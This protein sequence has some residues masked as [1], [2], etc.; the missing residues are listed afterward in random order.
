MP[1]GGLRAAAR[2]WSICVVSRA[3]L[4]LIIEDDP[5]S[6]GALSLILSDWGADVIAGAS[7]AELMPKLESRRAAA[8]II[9]DFCLGEGPNGVLAAQSLL[10]LLPS[11]PVLVLTSAF[12]NRAASDASDAGFDFMAKPARAEA[13]VA[14]LEQH[15]G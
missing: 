8:A 11:A 9:A 12:G 4:I 13:I 2:L 7:L 6:A 1:S 5:A 14:W 10:Q 3:P 15:V